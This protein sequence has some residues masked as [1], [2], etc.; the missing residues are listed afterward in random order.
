MLAQPLVSILTNSKNGGPYLE[1]LFETVDNQ[2]YKNWEHIFFDNNSNDN[3]YEKILSRKN[4]VNYIKSTINLSLPEARNLAIK[5][6]NGK[7]IAILD[8]DDLWHQNK[9]FLQVK[10]LEENA[11]TS[12]CSTDYITFTEKKKYKNIFKK[13]NLYNF[14][15]LLDNY[16]ISHSS[17]MFR[18]ESLNRLNHI[19]DEDLYIANDKDLLLRILIE[20]NYCHV[21]KVLTF[22][23]ID[24]N[25]T[26]LD[27]LNHLANDNEKIL[28]KLSNLVPN[29]QSEYSKEIL[30]NRKK[31]N[32]QKA[33]YHWKTGNSRKSRLELMPYLNV[34]KFV[35]FYFVTF[36]PNGLFQLFCKI[37]REV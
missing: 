30:N 12:F 32:F 34:R 17:V 5:N 24:E 23:G 3:T 19:Y 25:S 9:L 18:K 13:K 4:K 1:K 10:E 27:N 6:C 26:M 20:E 21:E 22:W 29:F 33:I 35:L 7:Y 16:T 37:I 14:R 28:L 31:I 8:C 11:H 15:S 36:L 2:I